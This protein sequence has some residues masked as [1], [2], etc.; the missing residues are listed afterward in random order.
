MFS[1]RKIFLNGVNQSL[2]PA[3]TGRSYIGT[4]V[5]FETGVARVDG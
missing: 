4:V 2:P 1:D 3:E 5:P